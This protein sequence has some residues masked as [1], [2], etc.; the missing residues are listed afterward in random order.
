V[1]E[2]AISLCRL[3]IDV[4]HPG[5]ASSGRLAAKHPRL[6]TLAERIYLCRALVDRKGDWFVLQC[7]I[8]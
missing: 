4:M 1:V 3:L 7:L 6:A 2:Q 5:V 8:A